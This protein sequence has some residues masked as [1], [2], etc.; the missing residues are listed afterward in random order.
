MR[1]LITPLATHPLTPS[2]C[3]HSYAQLNDYDR[4]KFEWSQLND[5]NESSF[6]EDS[7]EEKSD[8][9]GDD[10]SGDDDDEGTDSCDSDDEEEEACLSAAELAEHLEE[11]V[12]RWSIWKDESLVRRIVATT[13]HK[14]QTRKKEAIRLLRELS[15]LPSIGGEMY[16]HK[17]G[18][19]KVCYCFST[20][21]YHKRVVSLIFSPFLSEN[22]NDPRSTHDIPYT[23]C[24]DRSLT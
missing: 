3:A 12:G 19:F 11:P 23:I 13:R 5:D 24:P 18:V 1:A 2:V 15:G 10:G 20:C 14:T 9:E 8:D 4:L 22:P 21:H 17:S 7:E 6:D 16:A